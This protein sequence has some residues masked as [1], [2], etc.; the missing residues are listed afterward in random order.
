MSD[1]ATAKSPVTIMMNIVASGPG[2]ICF[3]P[4][5]KVEEAHQDFFDGTS[6]HTGWWVTHPEFAVDEFNE[7]HWG[8]VGEFAL[9][10]KQLAEW[11][12]EA[13]NFRAIADA[14]ATDEVMRQKRMGGEE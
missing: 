12:C 9:H 11:V 4:D 2:D 7:A 5:F 3:D 14:K 13:L 6:R 1:S 10:E 8:I